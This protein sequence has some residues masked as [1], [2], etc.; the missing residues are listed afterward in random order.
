[1]ASALEERLR[2]QQAQRVIRTRIGERGPSSVAI[3]T[4]NQRDFL[5]DAADLGQSAE[6]W[7]GPAQFEPELRQAILQHLGGSDDHA[8]VA[9][10][11]TS[12]GIIAAISSIAAGRVVL[13]YTPHGSAS[14]PSIARGARA[15]E[16]DFKEVDNID[17]LRR[18]LEKSRVGVLVITPASSELQL[19]SPEQAHEAVEVAHHFG[20]VALI[21]DAYGARLRPVVQGGPRSLE[22]GADLAITSADKAGMRGP[23]A[24]FMAG[25]AD[26]VLQASTRAAEYGQEARAPIA[27]AVLRSLTQYSP[28][29][30]EREIADGLSVYTE[31]AKVLPS[32]V[33][34]MPI[35]ASVSEEDVLAVVLQ[36]ARIADADAPIV[37]CEAASAVGMILLRDYGILV[38]VLGQPGSRVSLRLKPIPGALEQ[39]GGARYVAQAVD[40]ALD[41]LA[42]LIRH[43]PSDIRE[44]ILGGSIA[45]SGRPST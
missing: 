36:R 32:R 28:A 5:L 29:Q 12:G 18:N 23:R 1:M 42:V 31:L 33:R 17:A 22:F 40:Q 37:P 30:L 13:S 2:F 45:S 9:F 15:G 27:L 14:H 4:G 24:G 11:R 20:V 44:L 19:L 8:A 7:L 35:G 38:I 34:S 41:H 16:C 10:N 25:R 3:F 39:V 6:E 43:R 21:D 26:L